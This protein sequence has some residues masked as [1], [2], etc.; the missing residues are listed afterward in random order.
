MGFYRARI[1][2][3]SGQMQNHLSNLFFQLWLWRFSRAPHSCR[4]LSASIIFVTY[5][6]ALFVLLLFS[7]RATMS[8]LCHAPVTKRG[9]WPPLWSVPCCLK[10]SPHIFFLTFSCCSSRELGLAD[11]GSTSDFFFFFFCLRWT[12]QLFKWRPRLV[13]FRTSQTCSFSFKFNSVHQWF[14]KASKH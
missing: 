9:A 2:L 7:S 11:Q 13:I 4:L 1:H 8:P 10:V 3:K 12:F 14:F 5:D 6:F